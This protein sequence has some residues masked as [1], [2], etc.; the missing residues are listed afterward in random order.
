[1]YENLLDTGSDPSYDQNESISDMV[2]MLEV[3]M[4]TQSGV[5]LEKFLWD[6]RMP[7]DEE[8]APYLLLGLPPFAGGAYVCAYALSSSSAAFRASSIAAFSYADS[9]SK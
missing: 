9:F 5:N 6:L 7:S 3:L 2:G 4:P 8:G 1:M